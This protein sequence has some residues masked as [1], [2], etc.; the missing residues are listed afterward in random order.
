MPNY[1]RL[2]QLTLTQNTLILIFLRFEDHKLLKYEKI[3]NAHKINATNQ[4]ISS[5]NGVFNHIVNLYDLFKF[6]V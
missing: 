4:I 3:N 5:S 6:N 1:L 2:N